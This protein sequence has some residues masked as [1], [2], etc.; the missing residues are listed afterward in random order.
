MKSPCKDCEK[1]Y[2]GCHAHCDAY[3]EFD[4]W[5]KEIAAKRMESSNKWPDWKEHL[6]RLKHKNE[7][8]DE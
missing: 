4:R 7:W 2:I 3:Q 6:R 8:R 5:R 1:R